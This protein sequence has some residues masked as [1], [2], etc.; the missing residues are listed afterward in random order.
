MKI[1]ITST[2]SKEIELP[3]YFKTGEFTWWMLCGENAVLRVH[4]YALSPEMGLFPKMEAME[5]NSV[6]HYIESGKVDHIS[7]TEFKTAYIRVSLEL[8]KMMN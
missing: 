7:E 1:T 8:E 6:R 2:V 5:P 4:S 3:Q